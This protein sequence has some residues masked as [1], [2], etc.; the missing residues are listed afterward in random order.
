M[1]EWIFPVDINNNIASNK[2][3]YETLEDVGVILRRAPSLKEN[4]E[5]R[6]EEALS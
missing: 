5:R 4:A 3:T 1:S 2:S 6:G